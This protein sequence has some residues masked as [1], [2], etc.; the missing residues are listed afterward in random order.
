MA[1]YGAET[2]DMRND[3]EYFCIDV[4]EMKYL[5]S[6]VGVTRLYKGELG[7]KRCAEKLEFHESWRVAGCRV[8]QSVEMGWTSGDNR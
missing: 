5:R 4:H 1:L 2:R 6:F 7:M 8:D 3:R